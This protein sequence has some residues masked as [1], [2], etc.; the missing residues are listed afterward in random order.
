MTTRRAEC[1]CGQLSATCAG[2]PVR[3]SVCHCLECKRRTG[4]AFGYA[5]RWAEKDVTTAGEASHFVRT[6]DEGTHGTHSFCPSC[7]VT[8]FWTNS[9]IP[10]F[11]MVA[12]GAFADMTFPPPQVSVYDDS[13]RYPWIELNTQPLEKY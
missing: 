7:G 9:N 1:S 4:S 11:V 10:G 3:V 8:V 2:E 5:G 12:A 13:R 6:G